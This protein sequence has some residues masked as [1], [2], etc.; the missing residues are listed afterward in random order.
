MNRKT[1]TLEIFARTQAE[2]ELRG[3]QDALAFFG[4]EP[5]FL[6][7]SHAEVA[8]HLLDG[9]ITSYRLTLSYATIEEL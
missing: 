1:L 7:Y 6:S 8:T 9:T 5:F 3:A 2:G 4:D